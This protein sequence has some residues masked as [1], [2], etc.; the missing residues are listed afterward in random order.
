MQLRRV[1]A[2]AVVGTTALAATITSTDLALAARPPLT[3]PS[4]VAHLDLG[5]GQQPENLTLLPDGAAAVT[6]AFSR[7][8]AV[9][10]RTGAVRVLATL[11]APPADART[12]VLGPPFL[13][14]I[15]Q[16]RAHTLYFLY[17]TGTDDLTGVWRLRP[18]GSPE[19]IAALPADTLPNGL[20]LDRSTGQLYAADSVL[21]RIWRIP[22]AGGTPEVWA[23]GSA[24]APA[25][26]LGA[27]GVK[28]HDG[29]VW[30]SNLDHGTLLRIPV[31]HDGTPGTIR[32]A[33]TDLTGIDDFAFT[34]H[35]DQLLAALNAGNEVALVSG[36]GGNSV[37]LDHTDGLQ[38]PTSIAVRGS[39]VYVADAA[40]LTQQ[41]PNLLTTRRH[42]PFSH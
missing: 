2:A 13:G 14:G 30:V 42:R 37:V 36:N 23:T 3:S 15:V 28:V 8:V 18:G 38:N 34:G 4:F 1:L 6:F 11:P 41:D 25:G 19:R 33:A 5:A 17:A 27:N 22:A 32:T 7:Q 16:G 21:G 29:A 31:R 20:A 26:F 12:P 10:E 40:Y 9:I 39:V 35:G 24:L